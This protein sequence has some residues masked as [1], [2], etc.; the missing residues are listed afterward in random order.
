[1]IYT[2]DSVVDAD[3]LRQCIAN[4]Q[5]TDAI[6]VYKLLTKNGATAAVSD[7][8]RQQLLEL[9]CFFNHDD[10]L[11]EELIE[12]RW[13]SQTSVGKER[14]RKT[15]RDGDL[16]EQL[17]GEME[18]KTVQAYCAIVRGMC[19]YYQVERGWA[20]FQEAID[21][22]MPV[23]AATFNAVLSVANFLKESGEMRWELVQDILRTMAARQVSPNLATLNAVMG[24][25][26]TI[27]GYRQSRTFALQT[28]AEFNGLGIR[29]SL[30]TWYFVLS[31]FCRERGPVSHVLV[32]ILNQIERTDFHI[33][34]AKDTFFFVTAMDVCRNHLADKDL[35]K[36]LNDLL[37]H[38]NNYDLI[39]DSYKESIYY[40][41]Y[42]GLLCATETLDAFMQTYNALVPNI[43]TPE[44]G[45]MAEILKHVEVNGA[46]E[47]LPQLWSDMVVFDHVNRESLLHQVLRIAVENRPNPTELLSQ[48]G[49]DAKFM[50]IGWQIWEKIENQREGRTNQL[51]WTGQMLGDILTLCARNADMEKAT[52]VFRKLDKDQDKVSGMPSPA[53]L[54]AYVRMCV[55]ERQPSQAVAALQYCVENSFSDNAKL[56]RHIVES[57]TLDE[58]HLSK[59]ASLVGNE[60]VRQDNAVGGGVN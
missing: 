56:A 31:I 23:D 32:D 29:P 26:S 49:L 19:K 42:F 24:V 45:I 30:A 51:M 2:E 35:A 50:D 46:L 22:D 21:K 4:V 53:A 38:G 14:Q 18:T 37:H 59:I 25:I 47:L 17:F 10:T 36:R 39:G 7:D 27:G 28:L 43:Y 13:F 52:E 58:T 15:W 55:T 44:P 5:V 60:V 40:R 33:T 1:M 54:E 41:H 9:V 34:H 3:A 20:L 8:L 11:D 6:L 57:M 48:I 12:E 16:A